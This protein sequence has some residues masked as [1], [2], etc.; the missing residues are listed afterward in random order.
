MENEKEYNRNMK[1]WIIGLGGSIVAPDGI[2]VDFVSDFYTV[3]VEYI[4]YH[5]YRFVI[6]VGGGAPARSYQQAFK[7]FMSL[8]NEEYG[9][10]EDFEAQDRIGIKATHLNASF[11][12]EVFGDFASEQ[13][14]TNPESS[15]IVFD[16]PV[17]I[18][19]GWKPGFSTDLDAVMLA[20][21]Y[22]ADTLINLSNIAQVY[23]ADPNTDS[24][25][26]PLETI[27]WSEMMEMVGS[28]WT[29]GMHAPFDPR[30]CELASEIGL[31]VIVALGRDLDNLRDILDEKPFFGTKIS[32]E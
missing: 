7:D 16:K 22:E 26:T 17:L 24:T 23:T 11:I 1:T 18:G 3:L 19:A 8:Q 14:V 21:R 12:Q 28:E 31:E 6:I 2:D 20:E 13:I 27:S 29:P 4:Q 5:N 30:A 25:A 15:D 9:I 10:A 32:H